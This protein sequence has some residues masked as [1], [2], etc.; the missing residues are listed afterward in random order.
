MNLDYYAAHGAALFP[1]PA[2][3]KAPGNAEFWASDK[4]PTRGGSF[5]HQSSS[6]PRQWAA[7]MAERPGCNFGVV[8][9]ASN[10]IIIDID[11]SPDAELFKTEPERAKQEAIAEA[12]QAWV[13][14]CTA[15]GLPEAFTPHVQSARGGWHVYFA[16]PPHIDAATLRQSD[17]IRK[18]INVRCIGY[19][20][21]AG[22]YYDGTAKG[23]ESGWYQLYP[24]AAAPYAA[25]Q[26][27]LDHCAPP[28]PRENVAKIG[29]HDFGDAKKLYQWMADNG[30]IASD[31]EWRITGMAA[32]LE[33]GDAG[34]ELWESIA[35]TLWNEPVDA[36]NLTRWRSFGTD[37]T[38][39]AVTMDSV[40][41]LAHKCGWK[42]S[43]RPSAESMFGGLA[44]LASAPAAPAAAP[45]GY[46]MAALPPPQ[47]ET[48][49]S[50]S[51]HPTPPGG[52]L[53]SDED[54]TNGFV[55]PDYLIDGILQRRFCYSMTA[56]TGVGKTTVAM[57]LAAHVATQAKLGGI[58]VEQGT[59][60]YFAG[61][62]P[63]DVQMRWLGLKQEMGLTGP[64]PVHF[65]AGAMHLSKVAQRITA[66]IV[67]K[68]LTPSFV[69]VD[70]AAAYFEGDND[71]DN[72]QAG[73]HARMLRSLCTLPGGPCVLILCHPTKGAKTIDE[74]TPRG[75]GAFLNEVDGNI[76]LVR[77]ESGVIVA[78]AIGKFRGPEF[79]ALH[80]GLKVIR[81]HPRLV[82]TKGRQIPT[83]IAEPISSAEVARREDKASTDE[84]KVLKVLC[85]NTAMKNADVMAAMGWKHHSASA[86]I[87]RRLAE[88]K[89]AAEVKGYWSATPAGQKYVN[90]VATAHPVEP[91][92]PLTPANLGAAPFPMPAPQRPP[93]P[94]A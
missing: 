8:G 74:M 23:E 37:P 78:S 66:E 25:P 11:N 1:L 86:R 31:E 62:N 35:Q 68:N 27:L 34:L 92:A 28:K 32:K 52:F 41:N 54:F 82:D 56:Q 39:N 49:E 88:L 59:V 12:W 60:I 71:N 69:V 93:M 43:V 64:V 13:D 67:A 70:T 4:D 65:I 29:V 57:R 44:Q 84:D 76:G 72:V 48:D 21:A 5:K 75:G 24:N 16:V 87:L 6:D 77:D 91:L 14:L 15:W 40:F 81:N 73:N 17:A 55:A 50:E 10:W 63:T 53:A 90:T 38:E 20:V 79:S 58:D 83:I 85:D 47:V 42:G 9:F 2:G 22:S 36:Q 26:G 80:F 7:W 33:F 3:S 30:A 19:T 46:D 89:L 94:P 61:E 18:R 51:E 45:I